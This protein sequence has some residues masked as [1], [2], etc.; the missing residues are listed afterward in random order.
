MTMPTMSALEHAEQL[1]RYRQ[2]RPTYGYYRQPN[3]WITVSPMTDLEELKY[4]R[5]GWE[6]LPQYGRV[7]MTSEYA[8]DHPLEWLFVQD[9]AKELS[10]EQIIESGLHLDPPLLPTCGKPLNQYH[11]RHLPT[12]WANAQPV[13]FPQLDQINEQPPP[14]CRFCQRP[15]FPTEQARDQHETV[16]HREERGEIRTGETL[17]NSLV[18]GLTAAGQP[19]SPQ[20]ITY[21]YLCGFCGHGANSPV[22]LAGHVK[23]AHKETS[24]GREEPEAD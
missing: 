12:C 16:M 10:V 14:Q 6:P 18:R 21:P 7:E 17:A 8:A 1:G 9:G 4:R 11:K 15:P 2:A 19:V 3:G 13:Y 24:D 23:Q 20:A 22:A 5:E